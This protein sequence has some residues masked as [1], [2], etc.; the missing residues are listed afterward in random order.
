MKDCLYGVGLGLLILVVILNAAV[1][2]LGAERDDWKNKYT[3]LDT[4]FASTCTFA[5]DGSATCPPGSVRVFGILMSHPL[6][7][8]TTTVAP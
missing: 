2:S 7:A 5:A 6:P 8:T 1:V 4:A 3:Q